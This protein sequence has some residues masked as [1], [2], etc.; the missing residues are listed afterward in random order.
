MI[1]AA[2]LVL[3]ACTGGGPDPARSFDE[4]DRTLPD[5]T[6]EQ[7][8]GVLEE[9]VRQSG[10]SGGIAGVWAPWSGTWQGV[11]GTTGFEDHA[12]KVT[13]QTKF[14]LTTGTTEIT[15]TVLLRLADAGVVELDDHV[16]TYVDSTPGIE[17]ITLR[18]LCQQ[19]SGLGDFYPSLKGH[20]AA[21]PQRIWSE[22][23]LISGGLAAGRAA[24]PGE[25][26][27]PSQAGVML[28]SLALRNATGRD[29][30]SLAEDYVFGPL[31]MDD[32]TLPAPDDVDHHGML[33][34]YLAKPGP[35]G[36]TDCTA[37][38]DDS[39]QSS[40]MGGAAAGAVTTLA[41]AQALSEAFAT[42]A[43]LDERFAR[44]QW[45]L[46]PMSG[47]APAWQGY[48]LG[49][50]QYGPMRGI[51]GEGPGALT[52]AFTDPKSGLTVVVALN[53]STSGADF[54]REVAFALASIA[55][56][57]EAA[58]DHERP[59]VEL[60]WSLDQAE[61]KMAELAVCPAEEVAAAE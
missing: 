48:G 1:A 34:G 43:L 11:T 5:S 15:C 30:N 50:A 25:S 9:A 52:A 18:Q 31:G 13:P 46:V 33:G 58:P 24:E 28:L 7:L 14:R 54:V 21:N 12:P 51:A 57:A 17:G 61:T 35:D 49:G 40:S 6:V 3:T 10:S 27:S 20:F 56:K 22:T 4:L 59:M 8:Q 41:D 23:E 32:T 29:W 44:E 16:S 19:T 2:A 39:K 26:W 60:P 53:D 36:A 42:G 38:Y 55:S 47:D 45:T 37:K